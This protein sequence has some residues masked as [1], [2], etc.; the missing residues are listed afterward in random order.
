M[1]KRKDFNEMIEEKEDLSNILNILKETKDAILKED[2]QK[3]GHLSNQTIHSATINQDSLNI[4]VAV[5]VYSIHKIMQRKHYR[6]MEGWD[7]FYESLIKNMDLMIESANND[8][9]D[10]VI[11]YAG[12]IRQVINTISGNLGDY[13]RD[14]FR[15]AEINKAFKIYEHGL[16][17]EKTAELLGVSL[18]DLASYIGQSSISEAKVIDSMPP[19]ERIKLALNFFE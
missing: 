4:I 19:E 10:K 9:I 12:E 3:L 11:S 17:S 16:S 14:V 15:K 2:F 5:L 7:I 13:I 18:W 6:E 8:E 1:P